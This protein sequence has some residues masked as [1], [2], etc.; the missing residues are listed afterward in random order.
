MEGDNNT[1]TSVLARFFDEDKCQE[2]R[3]A[4]KI[5]PWTKE[6]VTKYYRKG[7]ES[8]EKELIHQFVDAVR[9]ARQVNTMEQLSRTAVNKDLLQDSSDDDE[10][11]SSN[12]LSDDDESDTD[13]ELVKPS[14]EENLTSTEFKLHDV[15]WAKQG[16]YCYWPCKIIHVIKVKKDTKYKVE[17][18]AW[19]KSQFS[20]KKDR[21]KR[22]STTQKAQIENLKAAA[23]KDPFVKQVD[24]PE[25]VCNICTHLLLLSGLMWMSMC[26]MLGS[27]V[28]MPLVKMRTNIFVNLHALY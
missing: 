14:Q 26:M 8:L 15:V 4:T 21:L 5:A 28:S 6:N 1:I 10:A 25:K 2:V 12:E 17:Y 7:L 22:F 19:D 13:D 23:L 3:S 24:D 27:F 16:K 18:I 11:K 20:V 9:A